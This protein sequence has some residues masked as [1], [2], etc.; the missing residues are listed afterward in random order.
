MCDRLCGVKKLDRSPDLDVRRPGRRGFRLAAVVASMLYRLLCGLLRLLVHLGIEERDLEI[1]VLRHQLK[2][3]NRGGAR[4]RFTTANRAL[5]AAASRLVGRERWSSFLV[6]PDTLTRWHRQL[7]SGRRRPTRRPG[8]P[9]L[10]PGIKALVLRLGRE[11]PR[12]GY[13]RMRGELLRLGVDIS[14][15]TIAAVL[16]RG[17]LGPAP[18]RIGPTWAQFL[19]LQAYAVLSG[20]NHDLEDFPVGPEGQAPASIGKDGDGLGDDNDGSADNCPSSPHPWPLGAAG[21][22]SSRSTV[23]TGS[24]VWGHARDAPLV[25]A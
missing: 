25:A 13:L 19:R 14:A 8:R 3:L 17:R 11:N 20:E 18:R 10:D 23:V 22:C 6:A 1:V 9:P 15:T 12:W 21:A 24:G 7:L 16:R 2:V 5:L 4:P